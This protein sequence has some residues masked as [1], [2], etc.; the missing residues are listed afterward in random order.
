METLS[1]ICDNT[2]SSEVSPKTSEVSP[3]TSEVSPKTNVVHNFKIN[4]INSKEDAT[5]FFSNDVI[6]IFAVFDGHGGKKI[7]NIV[8]N[9]TLSMD[10][11][12]TFLGNKLTNIENGVDFKDHIIEGFH[13]YDILLSKYD[14][15]STFGTTAT[16]LILFKSKAYIAYIGDSKAIVLKDKKI[17]VET[18]EHKTSCNEGEKTRIKQYNVLMRL[19]NDIEVISE[20]TILT[21]KSVYNTFGTPPRTE[22][23]VVTRA[24]GH[25]FS[26]HN[27]LNQA[28]IATPSIITVDLE[29]SGSY[30]FIL[31]SDGVWD[32]FI[33]NSYEIILNKLIEKA[34][35]DNLKVSHVVADYAEAKWK[36]KWTIVSPGADTIEYAMV[37]GQWDDI[38]CVYIKV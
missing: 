34:T 11:F 6:K 22:T 17:I 10:S 37:N 36:Q 20:D 12:C 8:S 19:T 29:D 32:M 25:Y 23:L 21:T 13:E 18:Q 24:F 35:H 31:A 5:G 4:N 3:K 14:P 38:S 33:K 1:E 30:E 27:N 16:L 2:T 26:R 28:L 7:V 15:Y 9:G